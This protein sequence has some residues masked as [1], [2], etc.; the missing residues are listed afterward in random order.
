M[1]RV[2]DVSTLQ[3]LRAVVPIWA[4]QTLV[5]DTIDELV[6][7]I[8]HCGVAC[9]PARVAQRIGQGRKRCL[10]GSSLE[11][12]PWV[13]AVLVHSVA[14][15]AQIVVFAYVAGNKFLLGEHCQD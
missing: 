7:S 2:D 15:Q 3:T 11:S 14:L 5:A 12:M 8:T 4:V 13:V 1:A 9:V 6:T 10:G